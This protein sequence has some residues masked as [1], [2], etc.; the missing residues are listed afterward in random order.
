[1]KER[2]AFT[3]PEL[4]VV[5]AILGILAAILLPVFRSAKEAARKSACM[6]NFRSTALAASLYN[7]DYDDRYMLISYRPG[8]PPN[9]DKDRTWVQMLLPYTRDFNIFKCPSDYSARPKNEAL[10]DQDLVPGD[11][12]SQ[13]Y[14]ASMRVNSGYNFIYY[15]PVVLRSGRWE[16][17]PKTNTEIG[18]PS[19]AI[20]MVDSVWERDASGRPVGGGNYLVVPPC[21]YAVVNGSVVDSFD[22]ANISN[23]NIYAPSRGWKPSN[24]KS[25]FLYGGAWPWHDTRMNI[26]RADH[27]ARSVTS[28]LL[29]EGCDV[30]DDWSGYIKDPQAYPWDSL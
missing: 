22:L 7:G 18:S 29:A 3:L 14:T 13:Y 17:Q 16:S 26:I 27:S 4:L 15:S 30:Q 25:A 1:M 5:I 19:Q 21:R 24:P 23:P 2:R 10:F 6:L 9:S 8:Q 11:P 12:Y 20:L 28:A